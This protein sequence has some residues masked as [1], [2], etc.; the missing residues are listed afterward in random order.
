MKRREFIASLGSAAAWPFAAH[1]QKRP[2]IGYMAI[3]SRASSE[4]LGAVFRRGLNEGGFE[5]GRNLVIEYRYGDNHAE[6]MPEI[7]AD[8]VR[9]RV[10]IIV[11]MGGSAS[12]VAAKAAAAGTVPV[13]FT[14][15]DADPV[16][17][18]LVDSLARPGRNITGF[19][20]LGGLL[21][22]KRLEILRELVPDTATIGVLINP[23]N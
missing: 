14:T 4:A 20:F 7:A 2:V 3:Q 23:H 11:A 18:G 16:T 13:V 15:G 12:P 10:D 22:V 8:L 17:I 5:D 9:R 6:R 21:G 19:S 1:A